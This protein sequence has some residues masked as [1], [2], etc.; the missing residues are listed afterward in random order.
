[1]TEA[2]VISDP[3]V[4]DASV[5]VKARA[6]TP[7]KH[8][9]IHPW[10]IPVAALVV[11]LLG[12]GGFFWIMRGGERP[13]FVTQPVTL[14]PVV[15]AV[16]A[17]GTVNPVIT[18]QV[19][20][21]VS[22]VIQ[23]RY[24]DYNTPVKKGQLCAKIDPRPYQVVVDLD[25]A[26][27]GV[28]QAQLEKDKAALV[29]AKLEDERAEHLWKTGAG[30]QDAADNA[31][32]VHD[33]AQAQITVDQ[34]TIGARQADLAAAEVN[35]NYTDIISPVDGTV[36]SRSVEMGQTVAASFQTPT[37]FL[38]ATDLTQMEVDTNVA[39]SDIG[40]LATGGI[41][42][43]TVESFPGRPFAGKI[44]QIRQSPQT[45]QNV[46]TYDAVI[47]ADNSQGLLKPGMTATTKLVVEHRDQVLRVPD[48]A[49][50]Y[51][52]G[53]LAGLTGSPTPVAGAVGTAGT[54][55]WVLRNGEPVEVVIETG[56]DDDSYT[57]IVKGPL[58]AGDQVIVSEEAAGARTSAT[59]QPGARL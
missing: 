1:M 59:P 58:A 57:E 53:G 38:V 19:G 20:T 26:N 6:A 33:Q 32:N 46:V 16:T 3:K 12:V 23:A 25:K 7:A 31:K 27:L 49:L 54:P 41:A 13:R 14:G 24:C 56:L 10:R 48:Q 5:G 50:R 18:V 35:L 42:S 9:N 37:L 15:R 40:V 2:R 55:I 45:I 4:A 36:V 52:P 8:K 44:V 28:A 29:Y 21:Y 30:T 39:E 22:G 47:A 51:V 34:A 43:F 11:M 17:S